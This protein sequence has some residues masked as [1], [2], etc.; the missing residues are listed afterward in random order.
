MFD[1]FLGLDNPNL[2]ALDTLSWWAA[3]VADAAR[4]GGHPPAVDGA[5]HDVPPRH[6]GN[7][8]YVHVHKCGRT[9]IQS[10][11]YARACA[12]RADAAGKNPPRQAGCAP[13]SIPL[14]VVHVRGGD[15]GTGSVQITSSGMPMRSCC[16]RCRRHPTRYSPSCTILS[17]DFY[18]RSAL[19][20]QVT[21][22]V[23]LQGEKEG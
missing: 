14:G 18:W 19:Q 16:S 21:C 1:A 5:A 12:V 8:T 22:Q 4:G 2:P 13:S 23:P 6:G 9:S 11:M 15:F 3:I 10:A 7:L 17:R 20:R